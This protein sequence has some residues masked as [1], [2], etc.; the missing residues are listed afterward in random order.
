MLTEAKLN[1]ATSLL[2]KQNG[3]KGKG[4]VCSC[5]KMDSEG[6]CAAAQTWWLSLV[7]SLRAEAVRREEVVA[8]AAG[9]PEGLARLQ[10]KVKE[11]TALLQ[12]NGLELARLRQEVRSFSSERHKC[13]NCSIRKLMHGTVV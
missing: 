1:E 2:G 5:L 7:Q 13:A 3:G 9:G 8:D 11:L 10:S 12:D 6:S 4:D